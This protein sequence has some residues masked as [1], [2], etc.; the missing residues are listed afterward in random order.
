MNYEHIRATGAYDAVQ[1]PSE[2]FNECLQNDD[3]QDFDVRWDQ[4]LLSARETPTEMVLEGI[5]KSKLQDSVQRQTVLTFNYQE[6]VRN[7]G[8]PSYSRLMT[9]V[10]HYIDQAMR[11]PNFRV[12]NEIVVRGAV[13]KS[14]KRKKACTERKVRECYQ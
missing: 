9:A 6:P 14:Q 5:H 11:T 13:T 10:R 4:A 12:R 8:Q 7:K 1:G 3:V 2:L